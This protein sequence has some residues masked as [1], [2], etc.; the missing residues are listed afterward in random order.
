[1]FDI[2]K[3]RPKSILGPV[4]AKS[5]RGVCE[6]KSISHESALIQRNS[7]ASGKFEWYFE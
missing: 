6:I 7:L 3:I 5:F 4:K 1:M 2:S